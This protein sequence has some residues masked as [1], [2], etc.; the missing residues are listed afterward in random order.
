MSS[1]SNLELNSG[2][3]V[4]RR[5]L[6]Y[7]R[8]YWKAFILVIIG[9]V[10]VA[11]S[12]V[13][14]AA[15]IQP[16]LDGTFVEQD[17][18][19]ID[20]I[21]L[22]LLGIFLARGVGKFAVIYCMAWVGRHVV[23][24]LRREMFER[25]L[26]LPAGYYDRHAS[27]Q[28]ISKLIYDVEQVSEASSSAL[29]ILV[30]D[31]LILIG[32]L[33]WMFYLNW[34]LTLLFLVIGPVVAV[35]I[36]YVNK[37]IRRY[38]KRLQSSVGDVTHVSQEA[39]EGERVVKVFGG[40]EHERAAFAKANE[41]NRHQFMKITSVN[42]ASV[43]IVQFLTA[44]F[45]ALVV[46]IVTRPG[47]LEEISVGTFMSFVSAMLMLFP[48]IRR[49]TTVNVTLQRG[50]TAAQSVFGFLAQQPEHDTGTLR[51]DRVRGE[52]RYQDVH[53]SYDEE[54]GEV[55][56]GIS[57]EARA[58]ETVAF[59]GR[60]G[61]GKSTL[62]NLLPRFYELSAGRILLDGHDVRD[63]RL[64][65]LRRQIALVS[66][67][68]TLFNDSIAHNI[69][70]GRLGSASEEEIIAAA[71]AAHAWEFIERLPEGLNTQVGERGVLLSG[72]Q[73]QRLAIARAILKDA[74]VL[75]LDEATSALDTESERYIQQALEVL[76]ENRTTFVIAHRLSTI[77]KAD[78]I[79]VL[80]HG[81]IV[82]TGTHHELL[83]RGGYYAA[84][85]RMQFG[86][87]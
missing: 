10:I 73:R 43:P 33:G 56:S 29:S 58:G 74:P 81:R 87:E 54:K 68:V 37:R 31:T 51:L 5:L 86:H 72:G 78:K 80:D 36:D 60:S 13:G 14:F 85:S 21:P 69:A 65:D 76:M 8:P 16:L 62:V 71:R 67:H 50:V 63:I 4:Y 18:F 9:M 11:G 53:F 32:L 2:R 42:A 52:V 83:Q 44:S 46:Y 70:Y 39:I 20:V 34:K 75:I 55:L 57:F 25:L 61:S 26:T 19:W 45:L 66:Q 15:L 48:P 22:A 84:L 41:D 7:V 3:A 38:A 77:E 24:D 82:E 79:I 6:G 30:Q 17:P 64:A 40:Q 1:A 59:V 47:M 35:L 27:G 23:K 12:E 49:L 28:L